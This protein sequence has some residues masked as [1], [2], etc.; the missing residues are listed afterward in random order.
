MPRI[1]TFLIVA[2]ACAL[3]ANVF[4]FHQPGNICPSLTSA[5]SF[6]GVQKSNYL[7]KCNRQ[8]IIQ[9]MGTIRLSQEN[10]TENEQQEEKM[11]T[12]TGS[13]TAEES[14]AVEVPTTRNDRS[15]EEENSGPPIP[16]V[17]PW[18]PAYGYLGLSGVTAIA[19]VG[20]IFEVT[21]PNPILG[22]PL[23]AAILVA[24]LPG[25]LYLFYCAIVKGQQEAEEPD[26][27]KNLF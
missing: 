18:F 22:Y 15:T 9:G 16:I 4:G 8:Q 11:P 12:V 27:F 1:H 19:F 3:G 7:Q 24:A 6:S 23:T 17:F 5:R 13:T 26:D 2:I 25:F 14:K 20:S 21:G 10:N